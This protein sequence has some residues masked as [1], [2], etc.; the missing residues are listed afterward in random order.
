M[1]V[2]DRPLKGFAIALEAKTVTPRMALR[3]SDFIFRL[4]FVARAA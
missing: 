1:E 3:I 2:R 4:R